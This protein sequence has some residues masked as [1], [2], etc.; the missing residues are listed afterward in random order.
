M[1]FLKLVWMRVYYVLFDMA[2]R[3]ETDTVHSVLCVGDGFTEGF[4]DRYAIGS[5]TGPCNRMKVAFKEHSNLR[6]TWQFINA[7]KYGSTSEDWIPSDS[8]SLFWKINE[9]YACCKVVFITV[10]SMDTL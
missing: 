7:G 9:K 1:V 6:M 4:G 3:K 8:H 2:L 5:L 10:G